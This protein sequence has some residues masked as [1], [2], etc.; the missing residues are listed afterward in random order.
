MRRRCNCLNVSGV[1]IAFYFGI[2]IIGLIFNDTGIVYV[3]F[4]F[5]IAHILYESII[6]YHSDDVIF[7]H[8][9]FEII[10]QINLSCVKELEYDF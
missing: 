8:G 7:V 5:I 6:K 4:I 10:N 2:N 9:I 1:Q 3:L